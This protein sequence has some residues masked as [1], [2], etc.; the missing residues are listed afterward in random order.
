MQHCFFWVHATVSFFSSLADIAG[1]TV[2]YSWK[3]RRYGVEVER[4]GRPNLKWTSWE[5]VHHGTTYKT[6]GCKRRHL[7]RIKFLIVWLW[8]GKPLSPGPMGPCVLIL[9]VSHGVHTEFLPLVVSSGG[10]VP[11]IHLQTRVPI[12]IWRV[13]VE[14]TFALL[15]SLKSD[16]KTDRHTLTF[17]TSVLSF[18]LLIFSDGSDRAKQV[19]SSFVNDG[20]WWT[21][22]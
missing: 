21:V 1:A 7:L 15:L 20:H 18:P 9:S 12:E 6:H 5:C 17:S 3:R 8:C 14:V 22:V 11:S 4:S 13:H 2:L 19:V 16:R 10:I